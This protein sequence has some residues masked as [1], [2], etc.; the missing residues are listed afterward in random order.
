[1]SDCRCRIE[2]AVL[3]ARPGRVWVEHHEHNPRPGDVPLG[4]P[5]RCDDCNE[6]DEPPR[7]A[8]GAKFLVPDDIALWEC[9]VCGEFSMWFAHLRVAYQWLDRDH[10]HKLIH[11]RRGLGYVLSEAP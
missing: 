9:S 11:T 6:S 10:P 8:Y 1:M 7:E 3:V 4:K 2:D 5:C